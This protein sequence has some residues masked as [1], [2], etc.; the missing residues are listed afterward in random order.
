MSARRLG[1]QRLERINGRLV[2]VPDIGPRPT[3]A[4]LTQPHGTYVC[5]DPACEDCCA[6]DDPTANGSSGAVSDG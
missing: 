5:S 3:K 6:A 2:S 1:A 4:D